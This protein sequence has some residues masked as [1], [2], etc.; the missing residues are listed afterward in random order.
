MSFGHPLLLLTLLVLPLAAAVYFWLER[1][2][3]K[4]TMTFTNMDV[5]A[6]VAAGRSYRRY[7]PPALALRALTSLCVALARP[8][9]STM[10]PSDRA[11]VVLVVDV[12]GSM[13][14]TDIKP[15]R[16]A[17]AQAAVRKF[18]DK[19]PSR[20][21]VALIAFA[22]DPQVAAP[23]TT[24]REVV[25]EGLN[26]LTF[27]SGYGGTAIGDALAA[28]VELVKPPAGS[29]AQTIAYTTA[30]NTRKSPVS[31]LFL[32][33][34]HQTRG[35]LE[36][37]EGAARAKAVGIPVYTIALGTPN[38]VLTRPPG[39]FGGGFGGG[40]GGGGFNGT[41]IPV[42][43]DPATLRQIAQTT[44]GK[45]FDARSAKAVESAYSHLGSVVARV[46]GKKE[47]T[48]EF[49]GCRHPAG[50]GRGVLGA[51]RTPPTLTPTGLGDAAAARGGA[52]D[53]THDQP[54]SDREDEPGHDRE[55]HQDDPLR[56][57]VL[58]VGTGRTD[59]CES[60]RLPRHIHSGGG[61]GP[62]DGSTRRHCSRRLGRPTT[63]TRTC[64]VRPDLAGGGF[65]S[66]DRG[67]PG[68]TVLDVA[69]GT[70]AVAA[71]LV[72]QKGCGRRPDQSAEMLAEARRRARRRPPGRG[73]ADHLPFRTRRSPADL[74]VPDA[75]STSRR[76]PPELARVVEPGGT[77]AGSSSA[78]RRIRSRGRLAFLRGAGLPSSGA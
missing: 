5:L 9:R 1:R 24:D 70:G 11:T 14:A 20:V 68:D 37:L 31:I 33:D 19:V 41:Q 43:P 51:R 62:P 4:Y 36:P 72:R 65:W 77:V 45:F 2:P 39:G 18:L 78:C 25:R 6:S 42:P 16:L 38:G 46:H 52:Q 48:N 67:S 50:R 63:V 75:P 60:A 27:F 59:T 66:P 17:A 29:G 21:R 57:G 54:A 3:A 47:A 73:E 56:H 28:A 53:P 7:V 61:G 8:H 15:T 76:D 12:S 58:T 13:Q 22:G 10:I 34:G 64:S 30:A 49:L 35:L 69:T 55:R 26:S 23:P 71:E 40:G 32:S 74:H 44:G